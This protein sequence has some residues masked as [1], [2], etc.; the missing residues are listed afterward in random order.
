M[1][2]HAYGTAKTLPAQQKV[3]PKRSE[4]VKISVVIPVYNVS[5]DYLRECLKSLMAQTYTNG[6]FIIVIDGATD[7]SPEICNEFASADERFR[8]FAR[9]NSGAGASRNFGLDMA[10]G[11]YIMFMDSDDYWLDK[12][13]METV[14]ELLKESGA[15]ILSFS[16]SEF[17]D[18]S[19]KPVASSQDCLSREKIL[20]NPA[21]VKE[22][23]KAPR[24]TFSSSIITKAVK[25]SFI[26]NNNIRF[27]E[28]IN[29]EDTHFSAQ[30]VYYGRTY[31]RLNRRVYAVRR[32]RS[33]T[34]RSS[35]ADVRV[36]KSMMVVFDD[37]TERFS[38]NKT[39][40][41]PVLDF[42]ASP[43]LYTLGKAAAVADL[44]PYMAQLKK[45][46]YLLAHSS[47]PYVRLAGLV[48]RLCGLRLTLVALRIFL[49]LNH[50]SPVSIDKKTKTR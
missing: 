39:S 29:G 22:L 43:Y 20:N 21:A 36:L 5:E 48:A 30:L 17:Y 38:L 27:L 32:H 26:E 19:K 34:S 13:L 2:G 49:S 47:R 23:L 3:P 31:D 8:V 25:R 33:S 45:Y 46:V 35:H 28:G 40:D 15:D 24:S 6:E 50:R 4:G 16:Y 37:I 1:V 7:H 44:S 41:S 9:E 12:K 11:E 42:L 14:A 18:D 10:T